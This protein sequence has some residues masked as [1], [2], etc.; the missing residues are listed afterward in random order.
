MV[1]PFIYGLFD[2]DYGRSFYD[3]LQG[4]V[5][6]MENLNSDQISMPS[7]FKYRVALEKQVN[8]L[9]QFHAKSDFELDKTILQITACIMLGTFVSVLLIYCNV[10]SHADLFGIHTQRLMDLISFIVPVIVGAP[11]TQL[12]IRI[13][14]HIIRG[15]IMNIILCSLDY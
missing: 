8:V 6:V 12:S 5:N 15:M 3:V 2:A 9:N 4:V 10:P 11:P 14:F 1:L 13:M 7:N